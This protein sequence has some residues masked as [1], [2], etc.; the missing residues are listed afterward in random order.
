MSSNVVRVEERPPAITSGPAALLQIAVERGADVESLTKLMDLQ[1]RY[2]ANESRKAYNK[3]FAAFRSDPPKIEKNKE[4]RYGN[5]HYSHATL[6]HVA[7]VIG[8]R[9]AE[10]GLSFRWETQQEDAKITVTCWVSHVDGHREATTL[11]AGA[12]TSGQKNAIQAIGSAVS[13]LQRYTLLAATGLAASDM[14]DDGQGVESPRISED[15][16]DTI[17]ALAEE[18]GANWP[19][20]TKYM[21][22]REISELPAKRYKDAI[23]ALEGKRK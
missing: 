8:E 20:F 12:D 7:D 14:D 18:V 6:N 23:A 17:R 16:A 3:A 9:M 21:N 22:V 2:E 13:Y 1:E 11:S 5:T 19:A 10:H 15:Q 4:V